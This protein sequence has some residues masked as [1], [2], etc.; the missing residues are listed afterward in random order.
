MNLLCR[1]WEN[2]LFRWYKAHAHIARLLGEMDVWANYECWAY[3][4][5]RRLDT[6]RVQ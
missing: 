4:A 1:V 2:Y 3:D 5:Q 6:L